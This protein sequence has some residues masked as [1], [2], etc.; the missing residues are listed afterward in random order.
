MDSISLKIPS[1]GKYKTIHEYEVEKYE[2]R[3]HKYKD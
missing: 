3:N 1:E 2:Y